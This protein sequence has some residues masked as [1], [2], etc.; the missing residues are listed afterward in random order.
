[1]GINNRVQI[2]IDCLSLVGFSN[3]D[4]QRFEAAF[5]QELTILLSEPT[6]RSFIANETD[7]LAGNVSIGNAETMGRDVAQTIFRGITNG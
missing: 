1:M 5:R 6:E 4:A 2:S 7:Q 3:R